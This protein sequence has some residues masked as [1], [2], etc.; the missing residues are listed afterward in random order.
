MKSTLIIVTVII[1]TLLLTCHSDNKAQTE[2]N[3]DRWGVPHIMAKTEEQLFYAQGWAQMK[4]HSNLI[5]ELYGKARGRGA[6]YW[7]KQFEQQAKLVHVL[8]FPGLAAE[9]KQKQDSRL[10]KLI[11]AFVEGANEYARKNPSAIAKDRQ[12]V[13]PITYDD[14]NLHYLNVIY[15][16]FM[17]GNDVGGAM[18][19][20]GAGS[21]S[22]A[23]GP[24]RSESK[25]A[26]LVQ[27]PHLPWWG[28]FTWVEMHLL[29]DNINCYGATLVGFPGLPIAF[30]EN[31][32]WTHTVNTIDVVDTYQL[33]LKGDRYLLDGKEIEFEKSQATFRV[34]LDDGKIGEQNLEILHSKHGPVIAKNKTNAFAIRISGLNAPNGML[35]WWRMATASSFEQFEEA[36]R[37]QQIP[38]FNV[39]YADKQN[40]IFYLSNGLIPKRKQQSWEYWNRIIPGGKSEDIWNEVHSYGELPKLKN[41]SNGWLQNANDPPWS[42]TF[43]M[44]LQ[45]KD[46]PAY[47]SPSGMGFRPQRSVR[48]LVEDESI[49]F[50]ELVSYKMSTRFELA[51]R[52]LDDLFIAIDKYG[53]ASSKEAKAVLEKWD[54]QGDEN[55]KGAY[56]FQKWRMKLFNYKDIFSKPW[57]ENDPRATPDG[58]ANPQLAV[59]VL[60]QAAAE[61]KKEYGRLDVAWGEVYRLKMDS[62]DL[63]ANGGDDFLGAF[64]VVFAAEDRRIIGGDSYVGIIEFGDKVKASVLLSYGNSSVS[65]S[66]NKGD[67][68]KLFSEKKLRKAAFYKEDVLKAKVSTETLIAK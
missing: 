32:G 47:M 24:S 28:E 2:I 18:R 50:D 17:A 11:S 40:N 53:S 12:A 1:P 65:G 9:W 10:V 19:N 46:F 58:L 21:N 31:L 4:L 5:L 59:T 6:E 35:Q 60:D 7:G 34:K 23:I 55:S 43:P 68:L 14:V 20:V 51:D 36:L 49:S 48:M 67:Q 64:R 38:Y 66:P 39:M 16:I 15:G 54:R 41:P 3:W 13:L 57:S 44:K 42:C 26:M 25:N 37:M 30:N 56:L 52:I 22:W 33:D 29:T 61:I 27:N 63:P 45:R 62:I 8:G